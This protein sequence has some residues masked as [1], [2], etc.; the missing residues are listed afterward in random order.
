MEE[1]KDTCV[2]GLEGTWVKELEAWVEA[3]E[4]AL[5]EGLEGAWAEGF[6][7]RIG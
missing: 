7:R 3:L 2:E 5:V 1:F 4:G 6:G